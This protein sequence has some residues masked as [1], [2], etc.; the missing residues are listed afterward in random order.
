MEYERAIH[1][2]IF[3]GL[4][5]VFH[6][7]HPQLASVAALIFENP[8]NTFE[9]SPDAKFASKISPLDCLHFYKVDI[10]FGMVGIF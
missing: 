2:S 1:W 10:D 4:D 8:I 3:S 6:A 7:K 5:T 9:I